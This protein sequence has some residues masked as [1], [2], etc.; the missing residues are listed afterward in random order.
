MLINYYLTEFVY[1]CRDIVSWISAMTSKTD[2]TD[3]KSV[4]T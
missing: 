4:R 2:L 3:Y 1:D